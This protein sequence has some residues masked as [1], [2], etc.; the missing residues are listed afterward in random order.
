MDDL[1][2]DDG[3]Q[4]GD[5]S[6][7]LTETV[8]ILLIRRPKVTGCNTRPLWNEKQWSR[9]AYCSPIA[10][11][12]YTFERGDKWQPFYFEL[13]RAVGVSAYGVDDSLGRPRPLRCVI[14]G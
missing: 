2:Y 4:K 5:E 13:T 3:T 14:E 7:G 1:V 11:L 6:A 9:L 10:S 12:R 8:N